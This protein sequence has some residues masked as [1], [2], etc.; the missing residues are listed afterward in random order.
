MYAEF[1]VP[2]RKFTNM[3]VD[4]IRICLEQKK[5]VTL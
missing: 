1:E 4:T 3:E 2:A 5:L